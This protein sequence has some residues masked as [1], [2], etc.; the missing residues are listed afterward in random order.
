ME[1]ASAVVDGDVVAFEGGVEGLEV[2]VEEEGVQDTGWGC[3][4]AEIEEGGWVGGRVFGGEGDWGGV[5]V[6]GGAGVAQEAPEV[7]GEWTWWCCGGALEFAVCALGSLRACRTCRF[8]G[9]T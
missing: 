8:I 1:D 3:A 6:E 5:R 7:H 2:P 9:E 4:L